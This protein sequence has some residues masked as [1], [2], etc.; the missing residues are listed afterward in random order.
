VSARLPPAQTPTRAS[1]RLRTQTDRAPATILRRRRG[2]C[3]VANNSDPPR[4]RRIPATTRRKT[5]RS[6]RRHQLPRGVRWRCASRWEQRQG[7]RRQRY[8]TRGRG[9]FARRPGRPGRRAVRRRRE[10]WTGASGCLP[11]SGPWAVPTGRV[12]GD[13]AHVTLR[14]ATL[15]Y[16]VLSL[17]A[18]PLFPSRAVC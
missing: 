12:T 17:F 3:A 18:V 16:K 4:A 1:T 11:A 15:Q 13:C 9:W 8:R 6:P 7:A 5:D 2:E 10:G 14:P